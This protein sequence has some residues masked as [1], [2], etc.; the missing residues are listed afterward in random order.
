MDGNMALGSEHM[1]ESEAMVSWSGPGLAF[2]TPLHEHA[3]LF[4]GSKI[5]LLARLPWIFVAA[6]Y[7]WA[8]V[9]LDSHI[10]NRSGLRSRLA[11]CKLQRML[12]PAFTMMLPCLF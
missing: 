5:G 8:G 11:S 9:S 2:G 4:S 1:E 12:V 3:L 7:N 6:P 10:T